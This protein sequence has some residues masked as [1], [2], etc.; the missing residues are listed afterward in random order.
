MR[1]LLSEGG[2]G[3]RAAVKMMPANKT[4]RA[5]ES[6]IVCFHPSPDPS[7]VSFMGTLIYNFL[8]RGNGGLG[9]DFFSAETNNRTRG[10]GRAP[11]STYV[12]E[13]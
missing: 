9:T 11:P 2:T 13:V 7:G 5:K 8:L 4:V 1:D 10:N 12:R 6:C 3:L